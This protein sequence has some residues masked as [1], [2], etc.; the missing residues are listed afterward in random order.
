MEGNKNE[1]WIVPHC[2]DECGL[3]AFWY[4]CP[5]C[6][7]NKQELDLWWE[8]DKLFAGQEIKFNCQCKLQINLKATWDY[9]SGEF[10][11]EN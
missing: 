10:F 6:D 7:K 8:Q 4:K 9:E 5:G 1:A 11:V 3:G 2:E